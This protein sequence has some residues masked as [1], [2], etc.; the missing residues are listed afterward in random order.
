MVILI[1]RPNHKKTSRFFIITVGRKVPVLRGHQPFPDALCCQ[2]AGQ[3]AEDVRTIRP[4]YSEE[5]WILELKP[6]MNTDKHRC[7]FKINYL[8]RVNLCVS[9]VSDLFLMGNT[10][11]G[12]IRR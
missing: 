12:T 1:Y 11:E 8:I 2:T 5:F 10:P 9:V 6:P 7:F 3:L 4:T